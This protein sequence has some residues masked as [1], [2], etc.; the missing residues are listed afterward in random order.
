MVC[1][2]CLCIGMLHSLGADTGGST[3]P[4]CILPLSCILAGFC[5]LLV[6]RT[7][8]ARRFPGAQ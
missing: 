6:S 1:W 8:S 4:A 5:H 7:S 3:E 2:K